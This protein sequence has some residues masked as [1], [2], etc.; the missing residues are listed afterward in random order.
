MKDGFVRTGHYFQL[1][2]TRVNM[3]GMLTE[4]MQ[5]L[6]PPCIPIDKK[7]A[8][9]LNCLRYKRLHPLISPSILVFPHRQRRTWSS[10]NTTTCRRR[11]PLWYRR[12]QRRKSIWLPP[13]T[14]KIPRSR[15][16]PHAA[17]R[18]LTKQP[19]FFRSTPTLFS[20]FVNS[21]EGIPYSSQKLPR[22]NML[23]L[24]VLRILLLYV[25]FG[26]AQDD[27]SISGPT[28][29]SAAA[30][31]S[32]DAS[33][34]K[35]PNCNCASPNPPGGISPAD[36]PMFVIF[37][38][39]DAVQS[40]TLDAVNQF[41]AHRKNPNGCA[42][43]MTY[44]VSL[45]FT[46]YTLVTDW[47]V[48]GNEIA[49]HTMT[50]VGDPPENEVDGNLI[51]LNALAGIPLK[52]IVGFRAPFLNYSVNTLKL[53]AKAGFTYD[54]S[55]A[56]SIPVTDPGTDA[57]WPYTL[58]NG[59]AND[60]LE[61]QGSCKGQ[62]VLPGF[63]EFP[64]YALFDERGPN[65]VHLMDPWLDTANGQS[66]V[67]DSATLE[68]MKAT[69]T[70][71]YNGNRQPF[72]LYTHPIHLAT[73]Y[74]GVPAPN[75]TINMINSFL[76]WAQEQQNVWIV[77]NEQLLAW[78]QHPVPIS[79]LDSFEALK[80]STPDVSQKICNG[81]PS[82]EA[83]LLS[84][85]NFPDFPFFTCYGCPETEPTVNNPNPAQQVPDGQQ[86]RFRLPTNCSTAFWDPIAGKCLCS[87]SDCQFT[88][89]S[90]PVGPNGANLTGGGTGGSTGANASPTPSFVPF[91]GRGFALPNGVWAATVLGVV[92]ALA[93]W[94]RDTEEKF[95]PGHLTSRNLPVFVVFIEEAV[96][97]S[98]RPV[99]HGQMQTYK[100]LLHV[101]QLEPL[102]ACC[103]LLTKQDIT[104]PLGLHSTS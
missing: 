22:I 6:A 64:M 68:Y 95:G 10:Q 81:M 61:V 45:N 1:A 75:S 47:F 8:A 93:G 83:G 51:A 59:M 40:Y 31:Y 34:C 46:N 3:N 91:N 89:N 2:A 32:C 100:G 80:C 104:A 33:K 76:D 26:L 19:P 57:F 24:H 92:G 54:S 72:G 79:Q 60:C 30:G 65:G 5:F 87:S 63:W 66:K 21:V 48:A 11:I 28:S 82:N 37:T 44:Y 53:L 4:L 70:A 96:Q 74:P 43:K 49:D 73:S 103:V 56:A 16:L 39:D 101:T 42:P 77:S 29:S 52:N 85:C 9:I 94:R 97:S 78:M 62:P 25:S 50:H 58:D 12:D 20:P 18:L 69:F 17:F 23:L 99:L 15:P 14:L 98:A 84:H 88:D 27:G 55:S 7:T 35:L 86:A 90:R 13:N 102:H 67:N 38:A 36:T 71:H 41:L